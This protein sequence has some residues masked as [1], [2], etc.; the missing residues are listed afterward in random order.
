MPA[1]VAHRGGDRLGV[2]GAS[3]SPMSASMARRTRDDH[4]RPRDVGERLVRQPRR[5]HPRGD[6]HQ[7]PVRHSCHATLVTTSK[8]PRIAAPKR[9]SSAVHVSEPTAS[10]DF[11]ADA[12][13][14]HHTYGHGAR[15]VCRFRANFRGARLR[16]MGH[17][18]R[19]RPPRRSSTIRRSAATPQAGVVW[20]G[21]CLSK[22]QWSPALS[23]E[24]SPS[25]GPRLRRRI[26][27][28]PGSD[29][30]SR[31]T[32][33]PSRRPRRPP[34]QRPPRRQRRY[35]NASAAAILPRA[36][37]PPRACAGCHVLDNTNANKVGPGSG[38]SSAVRRHPR[39]LPVFRRD[40]RLRQGQR[41]VRSPRPLLVSP[42]TLVQARRWL[43]RPQEARGPRQPDRYLRSWPIPRR[44]CRRRSKPLH[45]KT[46]EIGAG[47]EGSGASSLHGKR[48]QAAAGDRPSARC[49]AREIVDARPPPA[50]GSS[51]ARR[52]AGRRSPIR[53]RR[54][55]CRPAARSPRPSASRR[56]HRAVEMPPAPIS[57]RAGADPAPHLREHDRGALEQRPAESPPPSAA[58]DP[59]TPARE[60]V[61]FGDDQPVQPAR[62]RDF[63]DVV[64]AGF[65]EISGAIFRKIGSVRPAAT[66]SRAAIGGRGVRRAPRAPAGRAG[67]ACG[68]GDVDGEIGRDVREGSMP[69][70]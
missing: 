54:R 45:R 43:R 58:T 31:V 56:R 41:L 18:R 59:K 47:S 66:R 34:T 38:T 20:S 61:V 62:E 12:A 48:R 22:Q 53:R 50:R 51:R 55:R 17:G 8:R 1:G 19:A 70:T 60:S 64:E 26:D 40:G 35:A 23:S 65:G 7:R 29:P 16:S 57:G 30:K 28:Q 13:A 11:V 63:G 42:K 52:A 24:P 9:P 69:A 3:T 67:P 44:R 36:R 49:P 6:H 5:P 4:R 33:W 21:S 68:R 46:V 15:K 2:A 27:L 10:G 32:R 25:P 37:R 39:G 14:L